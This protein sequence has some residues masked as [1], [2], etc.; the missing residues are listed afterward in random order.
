MGSDPDHDRNG[1]HGRPI[2]L[3][4]MGSFMFA[5]TTITSSNGDTFHGDHGYAQYFIPQQARS[6]PIVMWHGLNQFSK[7]WE[8][9]PDGRDGFW[10]IFTRREWP[11]YLIDQPR[12]GRAGRAIVADNNPGAIPTAVNESEAWNTFRLGLWTPPAK[13]TFF[14]GV[15]F[16]QDPTSLDQYFRQQTPNT[17]AEPFPSAEHREF[18][19]SAV[20]NLFERIGPGILFTHSHSGQ[21]GW[22]TAMKAPDLVKAVVAFE[23]GEFAFPQNEVPPAIPSADPLLPTFMAPQLVPTAEF[24]KLTKIPILVV[25]GDNISSTPSSIFG[26]ELWRMARERAKQFVAAVNRHGGNARYLELPQIG[27]RGNTHFAFSDL[28]NRQIADLVSDWLHNNGLDQ[29][30]RPYN[31]PRE[32]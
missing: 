9:T 31:G 25:F 22:V 12:R 6:Y 2:V 27:I 26:V 3:R 4:K 21:Y 13:P 15:Q 23:P 18:M 30:D 29:R 10:Q 28:N 20:A 17:G 11:V 32:E 5:G 1:E 19:A 16:P 24:M 14:P 7:T 8:S